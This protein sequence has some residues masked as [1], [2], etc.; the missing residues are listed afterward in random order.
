MAGVVE[1]LMYRGISFT[2]SIVCVVL[3]VRFRCTHTPIVLGVVA[4]V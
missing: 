3:C 2:F 4:V 1:T